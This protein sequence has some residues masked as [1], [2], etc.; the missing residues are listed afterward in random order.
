MTLEKIG[1]KNFTRSLIWENKYK[2]SWIY[3]C[4]RGKFMKIE[5]NYKDCDCFRIE[6]IIN[7]SLHSMNVAV[8]RFLATQT[9]LSEKN[10]KIKTCIKWEIWKIISDLRDGKYFVKMKEKRRINRQRSFNALRWQNG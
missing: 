3:S 2:V 9:S 8:W 10:Q 1:L 5:E 4:E 6:R 7:N